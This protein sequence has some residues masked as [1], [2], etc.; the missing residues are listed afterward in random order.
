MKTEKEFL[1]VGYYI[2]TKGNYILK[3]GT[4]NNLERRQSEHT[5]NYRKGKNFTL[6][7]TDQFKYIWWKPLSKYNT[8]RYEDRTRE[9]WQNMEIGH[10]IR[11]D[12]FMLDS[13]P[14]FVEIDIRKTYKIKLA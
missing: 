5:R 4:T 8:L 14:E 10:F 3:I 9:K 1:Y 12:R 6:A 13:V 11:N 7:A 2:D